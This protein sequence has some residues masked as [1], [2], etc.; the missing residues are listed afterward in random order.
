MQ[1]RTGLPHEVSDFV[2]QVL[3]LVNS[4]TTTASS[5]IASCLEPNSEAQLVSMLRVGLDCAR[6][7]RED[8]NASFNGKHFEAAVGHYKIAMRVA[9]WAAGLSLLDHVDDRSAAVALTRRIQA[10]AVVCASNAAL[11]LM[12]QDQKQLSKAQRWCERAIHHATILLA[13]ENR[14]ILADSSHDREPASIAKKNVSSHEPP[15][16][17]TPAELAIVMVKTLVRLGQVQEM[18]NDFDA[19]IASFERCRGEIG[20]LPPSDVLARIGADLE[21]RLAACRQARLAAK[22]KMTALFN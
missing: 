21:T 22:Q 3:P 13:A 12:T 2:E 14:D 6:E 17:P 10:V 4:S 9:E 20:R 19:A 1:P 8:G 11:C 15:A 18:S 16:V 7:S 5:A